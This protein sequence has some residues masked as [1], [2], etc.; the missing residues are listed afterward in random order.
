V[1]V[2][3]RQRLGDGARSRCIGVRCGAREAA[4]GVEDVDTVA[5]NEVRADR[6]RREMLLAAGAGRTSPT[7]STASIDAALTAL[8]AGRRDPRTHGW[9]VV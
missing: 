6:I 3:T 7:S 8:R 9:T 1:L 4:A 2:G 5:G